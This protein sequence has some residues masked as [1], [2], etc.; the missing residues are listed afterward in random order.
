MRKRTAAELFSRDLKGSA[1][2]PARRR[3][4]LRV[5]AKRFCLQA[6]SKRGDQLQSALGGRE[7]K[8]E[9]VSMK[10]S[11]EHLRFRE[12]TWQSPIRRKQ[13]AGGNRAVLPEIAD[14][15]IDEDARWEPGQNFPAVDFDGSVGAGIEPRSDGITSQFGE[16]RAASEHSAQVAGQCADV[17]S[18][19]N[20]Q[21]QPAGERQIVSEPAGFVEIDARGRHDDGFAALCPDVG[22]LAVDAFGA[23]GMRDLLVP[24]DEC[25][26]HIFQ[27]LGREA[28]WIAAGSD[29]A[30][31][32]AV[33]G[34]DAPSNYGRISF[35]NVMQVIEQPGGRLHED[36][37]QPAG[38]GIERAAVADARRFL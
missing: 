12:S 26:N 38:E 34:F 28:R 10:S 20:G 32:I 35:G 4:P 36:E 2:A 23:G 7:Q 14:F 21:L 25:L 19:A 31:R 30:V 11:D 16:M 17:I 22:A 1:F 18:A 27:P 6:T 37:Q 33:V 8:M 5:A 15:L 29:L 3:A 13:F 24:A 9:F